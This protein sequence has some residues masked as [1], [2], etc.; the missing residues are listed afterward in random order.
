MTDC[1]EAHWDIL[2]TTDTA[3]DGEDEKVV[4]V[5]DTLAV[6]EDGK[7]VILSPRWK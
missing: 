1:C 4:T 5:A 7:I 2:D 6:V 3:T